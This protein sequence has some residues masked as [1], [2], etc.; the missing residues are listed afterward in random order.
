MTVDMKFELKTEDGFARTV[1]AQV[2][3]FDLKAVGLE[4][5][6]KGEAGASKSLGT[7]VVDLSV[8][9]KLAGKFGGGG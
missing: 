9:S 4:V 5:V 8:V 6:E 7:C 2:N 3:P 1:I